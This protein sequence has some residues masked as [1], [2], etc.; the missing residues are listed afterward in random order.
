MRDQ[1]VEKELRIL[2][3]LHG[4]GV[5]L[6]NPNKPC[7]SEILFP[8]QVKSEVDWQSMNRIMEQNSDFENFVDRVSNYYTRHKYN[9]RDWDNPKVKR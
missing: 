1:E 3:S 8:A 7:E 9:P 4:I 6:L 5:M 2:S